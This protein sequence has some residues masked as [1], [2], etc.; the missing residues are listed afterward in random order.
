MLD[1]GVRLC[2]AAGVSLWVVG[3]MVKYRRENCLMWLISC[4]NDPPLTTAVIVAVVA[5]F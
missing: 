1:V 2:G 5:V 4:Q 3:K